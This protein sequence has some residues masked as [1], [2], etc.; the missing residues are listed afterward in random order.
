MFV[1]LAKNPVFRL[2]VGAAALQMN[3]GGFEQTLLCETC[4]SEGMCG[5]SL[6]VSFR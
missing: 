1:H 3:V 6:E 4:G 2:V 5:K